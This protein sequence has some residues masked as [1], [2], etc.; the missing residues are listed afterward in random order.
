MSARLKS[1]VWVHWSTQWRTK[2]HRPRRSHRP[3]RPGLA[4]GRLI[5]SRTEEHDMQQTKEPR[6]A[7]LLGVHSLDH[8]C[9][10]VPDLAVAQTYYDTFGLKTT[11][12]SGGLAL[13]ASAQQH[14]W[15]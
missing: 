5:A 13:S 14:R 15:G 2:P 4:P 6:R 12:Q 1:R 11:P 7:D 10:A 8:F 3:P 9:I